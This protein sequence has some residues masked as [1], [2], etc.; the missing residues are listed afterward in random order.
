MG[1]G[2]GSVRSPLSIAELNERLRKAHR[3]RTALVHRD[4]DSQI[5]PSLLQS[6]EADAFELIDFELAKIGAAIPDNG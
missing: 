5:T 3:I 2:I 1:Y 4:D 6:L